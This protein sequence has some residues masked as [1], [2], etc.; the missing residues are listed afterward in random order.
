MQTKTALISLLSGNG[1]AWWYFPSRLA[2][3]VS[4]RPARRSHILGS[5]GMVPL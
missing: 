1:R 5:G 2:I 4:R 3:Q